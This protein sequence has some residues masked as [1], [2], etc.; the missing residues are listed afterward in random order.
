[1][2]GA[3]LPPRLHWWQAKGLP[4]LLNQALRQAR[5]YRQA[6]ARGLRGYTCASPIMHLWRQMRRDMTASRGGRD[7]RGITLMMASGWSGLK[8]RF[9]PIFSKMWSETLLF[10]LPVMTS[11][12][13][14]EEPIPFAAPVVRCKGASRRRGRPEGTA[15]T[16]TL[17]H[18]RRADSAS[19]SCTLRHRQIPQIAHVVRR[20]SAGLV[21]VPGHSWRGGG[22]RAHLLF[23]RRWAPPAWRRPRPHA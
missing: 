22:P 5:R 2:C 10:G 15:G 13:R 17:H 1:M 20:Q 19:T 8:C 16:A 12:M 7:K 11:A 23:S 14:A 3:T 18:H 4:L 6:R 9:V 21:R